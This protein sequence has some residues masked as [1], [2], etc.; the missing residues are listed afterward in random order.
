MKDSKN[1]PTYTY[2]LFRY[3]SDK[4]LQIKSQIKSLENSIIE[5]DNRE[6][7]VAIVDDNNEIICYEIK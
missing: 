6:Y 2:V 4:Y 5:Y 1:K 7:R 3:N